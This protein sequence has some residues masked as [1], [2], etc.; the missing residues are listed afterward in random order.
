MREAWRRRVPGLTAGASAVALAHFRLALRTPR[1][2]SILLSPLALMVV[3]AFMMQQGNQDGA[4][5]WFSSG[6]GVAAFASFICLLA[7][8]PI[9]MNQFAV[10]KA[11]LTM[12]LLAPLSTREYLAGKAAG[13]ALIAVPPA[14]F[15]VLASRVVF[16]GGSS[17]L[18]ISLPIALASILLIVAPIAAAASAVFPRVVDLN[19]IGRGGNAHGAAGFIG[20][21]SFVAAGLPNLALGYATMR[22]LERPALVPLVLLL[23]CG[24][25]YALARAL[26]VPVRRLFEARRENL[27][28]LR[29]T[30]GPQ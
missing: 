14:L 17:A 29:T 28:M 13:N 21:L 24:V 11:G 8:L 16:G 15:C 9:A 30:G 18:W 26:F 23:W 10:D 1:G 27:A 7:V 20:L 19:S 12:A 22:W 3:S 2:R 6:L 5:F 4:P 25:S